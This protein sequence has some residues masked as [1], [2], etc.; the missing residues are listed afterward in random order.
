LWKS[1]GFIAKFVASE[2][3]FQAGKEEDNKLFKI[4]RLNYTTMNFQREIITNLEFHFF[5]NFQSPGIN[6]SNLC[7]TRK[8]LLAH[9]V[10]QKNLPF[11]FINKI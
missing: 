9:S 4:K 3:E 6:F 11:N 8:K 10:Q 1:K 2:K 5:T 7:V